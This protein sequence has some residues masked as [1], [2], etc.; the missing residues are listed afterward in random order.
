MFFNSTNKYAILNL[1]IPIATKKMTV[2]M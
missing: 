2:Y 1:F